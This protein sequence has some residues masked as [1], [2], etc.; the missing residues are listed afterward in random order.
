MISDTIVDS[1]REDI[2]FLRNH[3]WIRK[4]TKLT[5]FWYEIDTGLLKS[6]DV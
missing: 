5:G 1:V 3:P 2:E 4:E 6:V